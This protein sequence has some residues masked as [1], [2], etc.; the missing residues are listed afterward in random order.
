MYGRIARLEYM[1]SE[2]KLYLIRPRENSL[3]RL[4]RYE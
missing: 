3:S 2:S 4:S 1:V